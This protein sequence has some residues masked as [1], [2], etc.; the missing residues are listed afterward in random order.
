MSDCTLIRNRL[1]MSVLASQSLRRRIHVAAEVTK[2]RLRIVK[3]AFESDCAGLLTRDV[4]RSPN[5]WGGS[6]R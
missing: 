5:V 3:V 1:R 4:A 2:E 6:T